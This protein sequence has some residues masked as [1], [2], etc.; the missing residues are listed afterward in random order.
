MQKIVVYY[1][2]MNPV[3]LVLKSSEEWKPECDMGIC[4]HR[5]T[6]LFQRLENSPEKIIPLGF[7][8]FVN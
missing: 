2:R 4:A 3:I 8:T 6:I 7:K 1:Y 5:C